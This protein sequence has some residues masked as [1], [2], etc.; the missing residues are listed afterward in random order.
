MSSDLKILAGQVDSPFVQK[1]ADVMY[2]VL[3][4]LHCFDIRNNILTTTPVSAQQLG[5]CFA[6]TALFSSAVLLVTVAAFR[7]RDF[8]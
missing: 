3:P 4:S 5:F 6:Y 8:E 7:R 1:C 2:I